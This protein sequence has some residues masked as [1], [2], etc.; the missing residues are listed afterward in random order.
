MRNLQVPDSNL[1]MILINTLD[2][3]KRRSTVNLFN[4]FT[5]AGKL[6]ETERQEGPETLLKSRTQV[7]R[8]IK[9]LGP[10]DFK[11]MVY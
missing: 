9:S 3:I 1:D 2:G 11:Q 5:R 6:T 10:V 7:F 8:E 4:L